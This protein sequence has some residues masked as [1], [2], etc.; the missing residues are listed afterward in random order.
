MRLK[1]FPLRYGIEGRVS[2][3]INRCRAREGSSTSLNELSWSPTLIKIPA[4]YLRPF[5]LLILTWWFFTLP[6]VLTTVVR[7]LPYVYCLRGPCVPVTTCIRC[8]PLSMFNYVLR[9]GNLDFSHRHVSPEMLYRMEESEN[10]R[11]GKT[12]SGPGIRRLAVRSRLRPYST[13]GVLP[14]TIK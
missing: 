6:S 4:S 14:P 7:Y 2:V 10:L 12:R 9:S 8:T 5:F 3:D 11:F 13:S 1:T